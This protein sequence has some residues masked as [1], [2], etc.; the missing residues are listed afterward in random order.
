MPTVIAQSASAGADTNAPA[1]V[2]AG[3]R[4]ALAPKKRD[5]VRQHSRSCQSES[6]FCSS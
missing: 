5:T 6:N 2:A 1:T 4:I 3:V